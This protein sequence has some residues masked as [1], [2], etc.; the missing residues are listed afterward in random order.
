MSILPTGNVGIGTTSPQSSL[1][2]GGSTTSQISLG[3]INYGGTIGQALAGIQVAQM[4][5]NIQTGG[6]LY[7]QTNPWNNPSGHGVYTPQTRMTI[8]ELGNVGIGTTGPVAQLQVQAA[9][10]SMFNDG[11]NALRLEYTGGA[12]NGSIGPGIIF[13][14]QWY[15]GAPTSYVRTGGIYGVK[16]GGDGNFGGDLAFYTQPNS[17]ADMSERMRIDMN[18]NVG[19]GTQSPAYRLDVAGQVHASSF[20]ASSGNNY[21][22]FVFKPGYKLEPL[23]AV[24]ASIQK[25]GHLPGIP[26]EAEAKE[27]GIDLASMQV[28]L[29]QKIEELTLHQIEQQ[30]L[31]ENQTERLD[32]QSKRIEQLEQENTELRAALNHIHI[33]QPLTHANGR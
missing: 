15:S 1:H 26:S 16:Q 27:H 32:D 5:P 29:L 31:L 28:K 23:S 21:A 8:D 11:A 19:I 30:K 4:D 13:A 3:S 12:V 33:K 2:V 17:G 24:E 22:D 20:V 10:A 9:T 25:D 14:Q 7:F 6:I 18:G